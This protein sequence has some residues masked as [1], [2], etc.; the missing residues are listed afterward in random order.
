MKAFRGILFFM[1]AAAALIVTADASLAGD[2]YRIGPGDVLEVHAWD[3]T[4]SDLLIVNPL[5]PGLTTAYNDPH[6]VTVSRDGKIYVPLIGSLKVQGIT[7][8]RL[9]VILLKGL[10][11]FSKSAKVSVMIKTPKKILVN[12]AGEVKNPG[13]YEVPDGRLHEL[14][15]LNY[16]KNAGGFTDDADLEEIEVIK[17]D[18]TGQRVNIRKITSEN[19]ISQNITLSDGDTIVVPQSVARVYVLG[20][21]YRPGGQKYLEGAQ[22]IDYIAMA[23]GLMK[24]AAS[25]NIGIVRGNASN[26]VVIKVNVNRFANYYG[27]D[28]PVAVKPGDIVFVPQSWYYN[29]A[30]VGA[31]FVGFRDARDAAIDLASP[32][33]WKIQ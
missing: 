3:K 16:I 25:D 9:E 13:A 33:K 2:N 14:T 17:K 30:D 23:G 22:V 11:Q 21:V 27:Q 8:D 10:K 32:S 26:P 5:L 20:Q 24:T 4:D 28:T 7:V 12:I 18:G 31:I 15:L 1:V 6:C 19:D 29:W